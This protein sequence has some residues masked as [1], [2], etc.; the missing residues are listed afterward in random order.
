MNPVELHLPDGLPSGVFMCE[1][2]RRL[3]STKL[4]AERCCLCSECGK[5]KD[6]TTSNPECPD[7]LK[8]KWAKADRDR[9][10][11]AEKLDDWDGWVY[12]GGSGGHDGYFESLDHYVEYLDDQGID[13]DNRPELVWVAEPVAFPKLRVD[14]LIEGLIEDWAYEGFDPG[15]VEGVEELTKAVEGFNAANTHH[16]SYY[17]S[18]RR[19]VRVPGPIEGGETR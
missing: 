1:K 4:W 6:W 8:E 3:D 13:P 17:G 7:C 5:V 14:H 12:T 19:A 9:M 18:S 2:C 10:A 16:V 11:R 15:S